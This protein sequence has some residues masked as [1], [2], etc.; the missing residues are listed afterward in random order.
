[1]CADCQRGP[2][3]VI[4]VL[5]P[6]YRER[7]RIRVRTGATHDCPAVGGRILRS[8]SALLL[9]R[10]FRCQRLAYNRGLN[11]WRRW[12]A[13][14]RPTATRRIC[15]ALWVSLPGGRGRLPMRTGDDELGN[16]QHPEPTDHSVR[17]RPAQ[18]LCRSW[19]DHCPVDMEG[20]RGR[21]RLPD[22]EFRVRG[23][24]FLRRRCR[25]GLA[26]VVCED[27]QDRCLGRSRRETDMVVLNGRVFVNE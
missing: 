13:N 12:V 27:E 22:R 20:G 10:S 21:G 4:H 14:R 19:P 6:H 11:M 7:P 9:G 8:N 18:F 16:V 26:A 24:L 25:H 3:G 23:V 15:A 2:A 17:Y 1:M 5:R